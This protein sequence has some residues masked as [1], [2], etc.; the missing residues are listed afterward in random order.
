[1][2]SMLARQGIPIAVKSPA[3][4]AAMLP[5]EIEKWAAVIKTANVVVE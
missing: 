1:V 5:G 4:M 3:D 2:R